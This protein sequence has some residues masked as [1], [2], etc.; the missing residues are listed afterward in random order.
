MHDLKI[1]TFS[2][3]FGIISL[4]LVSFT[5]LFNV[6]MYQMES[7]GIFNSI[8]RMKSFIEGEKSL[9]E[10]NFEMNEDLKN[11]M[12][13][14]YE[15][16]TFLLDGRNNIIAKVNH[17]GSTVNNRVVLK[18]EATL[19][20]LK[21]N[22]IHIKCLYFNDYAYSLVNNRFL[23]MVHVKN[24][25]ERL[26]M[27][28]ILSL[29]FVLLGEMLIYFIAKKI[30]EWLIKPVI[31]SFNNQK[32]FIANASHE[33]KTPLAVMIASIDCLTP[34]KKNEKWIHNLKSES[35]KMSHLITRLLDL[36]KS[37]NGIQKED[38]HNNNLSKIIEKR[39]LIFESLAY[40]K[41]VLIDLDIMPDINLVCNLESMD[42]LITILIDNAIC[43]SE[44]NSSILVKLSKENKNVIIEVRNKGKEI[45]KEEQ[46][47]I[48]ERFYR[49]DKA[50]T[51]KENRY[52]LGLAIAKN[53]VESHKGS[54][55]VSSKNGF[56]TFKVVF[57]KH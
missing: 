12:V 56:T 50:R 37:E 40:E 44:K 27:A 42:E 5:I 21:D 36:S 4:F 46:E 53:I 55:T 57:K 28:L 3:I 49:G 47:K 8:T 52:G 9:A 34:S 51:H 17:S 39:A 32:E 38:F 15:I 11:K 33:L 43:H 13:I 41:N 35:E 2:I 29:L 45:A 26:Q 18:A 7:K 16:Y 31:E 1:K 25:K 23:V 14:D 6:R 30:T 10:I 22:K 24:A 19:K 48:F 54:I 20:H